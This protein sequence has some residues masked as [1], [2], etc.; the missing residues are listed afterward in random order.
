MRK[1]GVEQRVT[2]SDGGPLEP[3][4]DHGPA[5]LL[6]LEQRSDTVA[7]EL[8]KGVLHDLERAHLRA[9]DLFGFSANLV[10][11]VLGEPCLGVVP[12]RDAVD[13]SDG[14]ALA[15]ARKQVLGRLEEMEEEEPAEEHDEGDGAQSQDQIAPSP[16]LVLGAWVR[17]GRAGEV[18]DESPG[19]KRS[20]ELTER[21]ESGQQGQEIVVCAGQ[22]FQ[23]Q[24]TVDGQVAT[25]TQ[26]EA[27]I[28]C[29]YPD[30]AISTASGEAKDTGEHKSEVECQAT[31]DNI[32]GDSP[33][34]GSDAKTQ[35]KRQ[36]G[37]PDFGFADTKFSGKRR[38]GKSDTLKPQASAH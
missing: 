13:G 14:L 7:R 21:P 37:V 25:Y 36:R 3:K 11:N 5:H 12:V 30:P 8:S 1:E 27:G 19:E 20:D 32:R 35:E 6:V 4:Q 18:R 17:I 33:E 2:H 31:T 23:E 10:E 15:A 28:Q 22:E 38:E 9:D 34:A 24:S 26:T 16:V 29:A